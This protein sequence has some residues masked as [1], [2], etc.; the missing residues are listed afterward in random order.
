MV[1]TSQLEALL[2]IDEDRLH[3]EFVARFY[4]LLTQSVHPPYGISI[5]GLWGGGKTTIMRVLQ[6]KLHQAGYPVFWY[7][8][9][10]YRQTESVVLAFLQTLYLAAADKAFLPE[11][12]R[13]SGTIL[14]V[15]TDSGIDAGLKLI[16]NGMWSLKSL[17]TS[18][19]SGT[20]TT[21]YAFQNYHEA[22][23]T[24]AREFVDLLYI[25]SHHHEQKPVIIFV[26]DLDRCLPTDV[27]YFLEALQQL[28]LVCGAAVIFVCGLDTQL[29]QQYIAA[30]YQHSDETFVRTYLQK[31]FQLT[32]SMPY[33][34]KIKEVLF[35]YITTWYD[36]DDPMVRKAESLARIVYIRGIQANFSSICQY[37]RIITKFSVFM[38][39]HSRY[40]FQPDD[41]YIINLFVLKEAW[42]P[43]YETLMQEALRE[44][45]SI[46]RIIH[47]FVRQNSLRAEQEKFL[48][49]YF[50]QVPSCA[51]KHLF[52]WIARHAI[53]A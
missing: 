2:P 4:E 24:I 25:I 46:E 42:R 27:V 8:P 32:L 38:N 50:D 6:E 44:H 53:L 3:T 37:L 19:T 18:F 39:D 15:L 17:L 5:D 11:M 43:L 16:T 41:D 1:G 23:R 21:S 10:K 13:N 22:T 36:W 30:H 28:F 29:A 14:Q 12:Y 52:N 49:A 35:Q 40:E 45:V 9:W 20:N 26:D 51:H 34:S 7:N 31:V 48:T 47:R 33:S